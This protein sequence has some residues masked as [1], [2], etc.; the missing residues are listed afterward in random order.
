MTVWCELVDEN[1]KVSQQLVIVPQLPCVSLYWPFEDQLVDGEPCRFGED[2]LG[3]FRQ[4][5]QPRD[6]P[7][8]G[9]RNIDVFAGMLAG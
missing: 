1:R 9:S 6:Q 5:S 4:L 3:S 8:L 7:L 2:A